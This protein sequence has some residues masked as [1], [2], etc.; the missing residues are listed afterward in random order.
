M[1]NQIF[2][3][4]NINTK[5]KNQLRTVIQNLFNGNVPKSWQLNPTL[6]LNATEQV[7]DFANKINQLKKKNFGKSVAQE[8]KIN[9]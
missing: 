2:R 3:L 9:R 4:K 1:N 7:I 5:S 6:R 8:L